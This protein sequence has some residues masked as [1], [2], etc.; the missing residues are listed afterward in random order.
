MTRH[1]SSVRRLHRYYW[2]LAGVVAAYGFAFLVLL[3]YVSGQLPVLVTLLAAVPVTMAVHV[4]HQ[5]H[6]ESIRG[7]AK[8]TL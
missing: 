2:A 5:Y 7:L 4:A 1:E 3:G 8:G 6:T